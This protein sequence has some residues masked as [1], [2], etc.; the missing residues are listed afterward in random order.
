MG[1]LGTILVGV[2]VWAKNHNLQWCDAQLSRIALLDLFR[3]SLGHFLS[4]FPALFTF[5]RKRVHFPHLVPLVPH[6][7]FQSLE[8]GMKRAAIV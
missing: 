3:G 1:L 6:T 8:Y 5:V 2:N 4:L 7:N